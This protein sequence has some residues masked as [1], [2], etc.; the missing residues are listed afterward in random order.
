M[1]KTGFGAFL[2]EVPTSENEVEGMCA[3]GTVYKIEIF[4]PLVFCVFDELGI[5]HHKAGKMALYI[6]R[7]Q[8][9]PYKKKLLFKK[10]HL[11][12]TT[13]SSIEGTFWGSNN[14]YFPT[15]LEL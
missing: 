9:N 4:R 12:L 11:Q 10:N 14:L 7:M 5:W 15:R 2:L 13:Y 8:Q 3:S 6:S 1:G